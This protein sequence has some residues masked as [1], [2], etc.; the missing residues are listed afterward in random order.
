MSHRI[1]KVAVLGAG[2]MGAAIAAH[3]ANAGLKVDLLD[4]ASED[5]DKNAVVVA[6]FERMQNAR[7]AALMAESV[8]ERIR[9]GNFEEHF[10]RVSE[11]DWIVEA[12]IEKLEPK[13]DLMQRVEDTAKE[14][15][16]ISTNTSG[17]PLHSISEER[18]EGF[19][20]RFVGTHFFNPP[21]YLKL[22]E[23]IPTEDTDPEIV[24]S[25]RNFGERVLG[26]GGV[27]AKDTPNF[28]GNRLGTFAGMQS[29]RYAFENGYGIEEVDAITGPLIGHPKTATFRLNDQVGLDIAVGVAENLYEAVPEDESREELKPPEKLQEMREKDLLGNKS[30]AGFYKRDKR[31][32]KTVFDVIDL[33]TF[34]HH[35]AENPEIPIATEAQEQGDLA[36]RLRFLIEKAD[37]DKHARY[38]RDTLLPYMAYASRRVPEISDTLED[39]DHAMEW[40]FA[41]QT[42][43]FRTWDL[44]GVRETAEKMQSMDIEVGGWVQ[45]MLDAGNESFYKT[46]DGTELQF[47][48]VEK[49]YV[50][51]REDPMYIS[52]DRLRDEGKELE[53]NDSASLLDLGDGVLCLEFHSK[54]NAIDA[55]TLEMGNRALAALERD[56]VVGLVIGNEGRNFS[57][58]ANLGEMAHAVQNG[59]LDQIAESVD[60]LQNLLMAFR[61]APKPVVAAPHGQTLG[62]GLEVCL[63]SDRIVA[64]GETY[65]GLVEVG[66]GLIP[67]GG[68][69]KEMAR[70]L[71]SP[72]L[73]TAPSTP[74]LPFLQK[75]FEQIALAKMASSA[76]E[77]KEVGFLTD[78]DRI[79][80]NA[81]HLISAAKRE[82]EDLADGYTPPEHGEN[83][84]AVGATTRAALEVGVKTLQWGR[85]ASEYDGVIAGHLAYALTGGGINQ[86]QWVSEE[87]VLGLEKEAFLSLLENEKTHERI[88]ALLKTGKPKRN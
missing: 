43:P 13:R 9:T 86:P 42:G 79:V 44:L 47:S 24:E 50:P 72:A 87:Y 2:T 57:V 27:I 64:A 49:Q 74:P 32:G 53:R 12:I 16:I 67:A 28:I 10:G 36:A 55:G 56:A 61:F 62:G 71:V 18:S 76:L 11:A 69:T 29:A 6:G 4:I 48:P 52:L 26:K 37:E 41:H 73:H 59:D 7:P 58:G 68:G 17:I 38:I 31:D 14:N 39:A 82:V 3:C 77:A 33:E 25:I 21:R 51:V 34:Q 45:E 23:I 84:Y 15:A 54:G 88:E 46:E 65:M 19:K 70:R 60:A 40:G 83:V 35:P 78:D 75:A 63:H 66:V 1:R 5:D 81:D 85:Y 22:M 30:G 80:M 8:A 20:K